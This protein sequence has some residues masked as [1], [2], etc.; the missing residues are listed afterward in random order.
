MPTDN[1]PDWFDPE[2]ADIAIRQK[3]IPIPNQGSLI[4]MYFCEMVQTKECAHIRVLWIKGD[5]K[6]YLP[7]TATIGDALAI[8]IMHGVTSGV[9]V[10]DD[11]EMPEEFYSTMFIGPSNEKKL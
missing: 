5:S 6:R 10:Y 2:M 7:Q 8:L 4:S 3:G 11:F 1:L 9:H